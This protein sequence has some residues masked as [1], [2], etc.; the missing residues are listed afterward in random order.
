M[1]VAMLDLDWYNHQS[2]VPNEKCMK[3]SSFHK[4][5][6]DLVFLVQKPEDL[7]YEYDVIYVVRESLGGGIPDKLNL[8]DE[9]VKLIGRPFRFYK[10]RLDSLTPVQEACRP[11]YLLYPI[12]D[13]NIHYNANILQFF[14]GNKLLDVKQDAE[15]GYTKTHLNLIVDKDFWEKEEW[16]LMKC[17]EELKGKSQIAFKYPIKLS[18]IVNRYKVKAMFLAL[19]W[20]PSSAIEFI[21]DRPNEWYSIGNFLAELT[22]KR[23]RFKPVVFNCLKE[24]SN[25]ARTHEDFENCLKF[26]CFC[27]TNRIRII[28]QAQSRDWSPFWWYFEELEAWTRY[29]I[30]DCLIKRLLKGKAFFR[31][32]TCWAVLHNKL[33]WSGY[34]MEMLSDLMRYHSDLLDKY[35]TLQWK[36]RHDIDYVDLDYKK[37]LKGELC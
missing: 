13:N 36:T 1:R 24:P 30:T 4:Q 16:Q 33:Y 32:T 19:K 3:L 7:W 15:N 31:K 11:D 8:L 6:G 25:K 17:F 23:I 5:C 12:K 29:D 20:A 34:Q 2:F 10:N 26:I 37:I 28:L 9:K 35:G 22:K 21:N 18:T 27:K 14:S